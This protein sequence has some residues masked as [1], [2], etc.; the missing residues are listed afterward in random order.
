MKLGFES[1]L[2]QQDEVIV[3]DAELL[4][5]ELEQLEATIELNDC[6]QQFEAIC[7]AQDN[8]QQLKETI[9]IHGMT[10]CMQ[11]LVEDLG[12]MVPEYQTSSKEEIV[13]TL[14]GVITDTGKK[15]IAA[16]KRMWEAFIKLLNKFRTAFITK[17]KQLKAKLKKKSS[18][19]T[20]NDKLIVKWINPDMEIP[21]SYKSY[22]QF[23]KDANDCDITKYINILNN[24]GSDPK[25]DLATHLEEIDD[26]RLK[27]TETLSFMDGT[28]TRYPKVAIK[29]V[30][31]MKDKNDYV[32]FSKEIVAMIELF[33]NVDADTQMVNRSSMTTF[34]ALNKLLN[35]DEYN[36]D[37][38]GYTVVIQQLCSIRLKIYTTAER[39]LSDISANI[40]IT[41]DK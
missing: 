33:T 15:A 28:H 20:A 16:L 13:V 23:I 41:V 14:E 30:I 36:K 11:M 3:S 27:L 4:V 9:A 32:R 31:P 34:D 38:K 18:E 6:M 21:S 35:V 37:V 25:Y 26:L 2:D 7:T 5:A 1:L 17:L 39:V 19:G 12:A 10:P 22:A 29:D 40:D 24:H 8:I